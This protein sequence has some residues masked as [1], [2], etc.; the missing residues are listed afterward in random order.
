MKRFWYFLFLGAICCPW[1]GCG[2]PEA[3]EPTEVELE[4][5][6]EAQEEMTDI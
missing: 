1:A 3:E 5:D 2:K 4:E 6:I